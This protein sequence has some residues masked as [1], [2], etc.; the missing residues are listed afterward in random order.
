MRYVF[1]KSLKK[2]QIFS[3]CI[4]N[5]KNVLVLYLYINTIRPRSSQYK[6]THTHVTRARIIVLE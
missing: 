4:Y 5:T 6:H 1:E 2:N 3:L